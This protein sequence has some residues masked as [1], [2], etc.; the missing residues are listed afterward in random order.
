M[1]GAKI[2]RVIYITFDPLV[3]EIVWMITSLR[4]KRILAISVKNISKKAA[5]AS[6]H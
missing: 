6:W 3:H 4:T 2:R 5:K 1:Y